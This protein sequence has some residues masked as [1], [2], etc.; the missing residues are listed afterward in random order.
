MAVNATEPG[1]EPSLLRPRQLES[2]VEFKKEN[3]KVICSRN[4]CTEHGCRVIPA[5]SATATEHGCRLIPAVT[6]DRQ[7][8]LAP[9]LQS[10]AGN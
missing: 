3:E 10:T 9:L 4:L 8:P 7:V 1:L 2:H 6:L 5:F